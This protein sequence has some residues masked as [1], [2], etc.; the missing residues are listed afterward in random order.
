MCKMNLMQNIHIRTWIA[1][2]VAVLVIAYVFWQGIWS[3]VVNKFSA[4]MPAQAGQPAQANQSAQATDNTNFSL[5]TG[6][7]SGTGQQP[8]ANLP[9]NQIGVIDVKEGTGAAAKAGDTVSVQYDGYLTNGTKFDSSRTRGT[10]F[11]FKLGSGQVI[12]GFDT[13]VTGMKVG[14][15][16]RII[17]PPKLGYGSQQAG[18]IPPNSTLLFEVELVKVGK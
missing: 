10:P 2:A 13:G 14:G 5:P 3:P 15:V 17:I 11:V 4:N 16:R 6:D 8:A 9:D 18:A 12:P 1:I 7:Q